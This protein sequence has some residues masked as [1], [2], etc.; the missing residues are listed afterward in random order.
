MWVVMKSVSLESDRPE[1][2]ANLLLTHRALSLGRS[3]DLP[4]FDSSPA[5]WSDTTDSAGWL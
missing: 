5:A 3:G 1:V 4:V 2:E